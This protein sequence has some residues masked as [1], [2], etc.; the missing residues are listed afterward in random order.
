ML[1]NNFSLSLFLLSLCITTHHQVSADDIKNNP[2]YNAAQIYIKRSSCDDPESCKKLL[3]V[4]NIY[5]S[6][7][8]TRDNLIIKEFFAQ[9][10]AGNIDANN[11]L[12]YCRVELSK[13]ITA[14][15]N[16]S[17]PATSKE[18]IHAWSPWIVGI[19]ALGG[20]LQFQN[21]SAGVLS[22]AAFGY[23]ASQAATNAINNAEDRAKCYAAQQQI[24][25][26]IE[27]LNHQQLLPPFPNQLEKNN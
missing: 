12:D 14:L 16:K 18:R 3:I 5:E 9:V 25:N 10:R 15:S 7:E 23:G 19:I 8:F 21:V 11:A 1:K 2:F 24:K 17:T 22:L 26:R 4:A 27:F 20:A 13:K 6:Q